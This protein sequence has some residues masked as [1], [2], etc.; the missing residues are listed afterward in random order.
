M[1]TQKVTVRAQILGGLKETEE[2]ET[3]CAVGGSPGP[4]RTVRTHTFFRRRLEAGRWTE[5][6]KIGINYS[7]EIHYLIIH[8]F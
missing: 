5:D 1:A 8:K 2:S 4:T 3:M 6:Q 7:Y